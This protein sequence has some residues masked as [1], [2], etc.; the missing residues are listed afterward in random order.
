M[1]CSCCGWQKGTSSERIKL[2]ALCIV[3]LHL[4]EGTSWLV[5]S[6]KIQFNMKKF[7]SNLVEGFRVNMKTFLSL[8]VP[9]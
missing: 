4:A 5:S 6:Y 8:A 9:I 7:H 2:V 1:L 3:E